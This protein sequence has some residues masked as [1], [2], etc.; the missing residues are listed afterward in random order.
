[1]EMG[2]YLPEAFKIN[3]RARYEE[4]DNMLYGIIRKI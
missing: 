2:V 1:M 4:I 3:V